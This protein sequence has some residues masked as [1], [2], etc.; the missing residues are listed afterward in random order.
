MAKTEQAHNQVNPDEA[1]AASTKARRIWLFVAIMLTLLGVWVASLYATTPDP[2]RNPAFEHYHFRMQVIVDGQPVNFGQDKYQDPVGTASC[3][4]ELTKSPIHFHDNK[5]QFVHIHWDG[6]TGGLVL[7]NYG[8]NFIGGSDDALGYRFDNLARI[9]KVP[10]HSRSLPVV[11]EGAQ[12]YIYTGDETS[13]VQRNFDQ[14][15]GQDLEDFFG[16]KSNLTPTQEQG[17]LDKLFPKAHAHS[18]HSHADEKSLEEMSNLIGNVVI[19]VQ[20]DAP[21]PEQVKQRFKDL[22]PLSESTCAG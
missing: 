11:P 3:D 9:Q 21:S 12:F 22:E 7:K 16:R 8:W 17:I 15:K 5:D 2:I 13:Y 19:F 20:A 18:G 10:S 6:M 1:K 4:V 14:F